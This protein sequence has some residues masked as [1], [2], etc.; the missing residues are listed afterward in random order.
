MIYVIH[1]CLKLLFGQV[2]ECDAYR[3]RTSTSTASRSVLLAL[4]K[5]YSVLVLVLRGKY[6]VLVLLLQGIYFCTCT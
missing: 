1:Y 4:E 5:M 2:V 6:L 3:A